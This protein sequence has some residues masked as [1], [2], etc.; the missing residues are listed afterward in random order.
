MNWFLQISQESTTA[1]SWVMIH[2]FSNINFWTE[3][4]IDAH[5]KTAFWNSLSKIYVTNL[6]FW[7][8]GHVR[9]WS[10]ISWKR[11]KNMKNSANSIYNDKRHP[12][13]TSDR[14]WNINFCPWISTILWASISSFGWGK[15]LLKFFWKVTAANTFCNFL[16]FSVYQRPLYLASNVMCKLMQLTTFVVMVSPDWIAALI[17]MDRIIAVHKKGIGSS[18]IKSSRKWS[19]YHQSIAV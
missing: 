7:K 8:K 18:S 19:N 11:I 3:L 14:V 2:G 6:R 4:L 16:L 9:N 13:S 1:V 10:E 5:K 12:R 17:S 15:K